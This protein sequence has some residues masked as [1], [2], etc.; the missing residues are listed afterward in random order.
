MVNEDEFRGGLIGAIAGTVLALGVGFYAG[1]LNKPASAEMR[2]L[3]GDGVADIVIE[4]NEG[5]GHKKPL[6]GT[7]EGTITRYVTA[8]EM[9]KRES[10][11]VNPEE[12][13]R[14]RYKKIE[15]QLNGK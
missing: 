6:Y 4:T 9:I 10:S 3:N 8:S 1:H 7:N 11:Y 12:V 5:Q 2:D 14:A 13:C 15:N